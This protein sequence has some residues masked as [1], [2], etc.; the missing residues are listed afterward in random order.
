MGSDSQLAT[1]PTR[2]RVHV[3]VCKCRPVCIVI[4]SVAGNNTVTGK[5]VSY[6]ENTPF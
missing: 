5:F 3:G 4:L 6:I 2:I 1:A